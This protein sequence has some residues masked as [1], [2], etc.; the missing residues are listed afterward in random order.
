MNISK[1]KTSLASERNLYPVLAYIIIFF[2]MM[3]QAPLTVYGFVQV[4]LLMFIAYMIYEIINL[5][6][7]NIVDLGK[8]ALF[9]GTALIGISQLFQHVFKFSF[10]DWLVTFT[11]FNQQAPMSILGIFAFVA[12]PLAFG[13]AL[14]YR[15]NKKK[16]YHE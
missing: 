6:G 14:N 2:S 4:I 3:S 12:L 1:L 11:K 16:A 13:T 7:L 10:V 15:I 5:Y 9:S 8:I